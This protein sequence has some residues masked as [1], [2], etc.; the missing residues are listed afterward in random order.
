MATDPSVLKTTQSIDFFKSVKA[1]LFAELVIGMTALLFFKF[2][3]DS[4]HQMELSN[5]KLSCCFE[6]VCC[7]STRLMTRSSAYRKGSQQWHIQYVNWN[8]LENQRLKT[9]L[10]IDFLLSALAVLHCATK[11][12]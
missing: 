4:D 2:M 11:T 12:R 8:L 1:L 9:S 6:T 10:Y 5:R 3:M 7:T